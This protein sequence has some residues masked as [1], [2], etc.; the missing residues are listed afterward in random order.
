MARYRIVHWREI[1][2]LVEA[3]DGDGTVRRPL[4]PRFQTLIDAVAMQVGA[5]ETE[6]Y[7]EGWGQTAPA[8][9]SRWRRQ[10]RRSWKRGSR[11]SSP[12]RLA[13][14]AGRLRRADASPIIRPSQ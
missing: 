8:R 10:L 11:P 2:A 12:G 13:R 6:A 14:S 5:T 4:S 3:D 9:P 7:L 1:P